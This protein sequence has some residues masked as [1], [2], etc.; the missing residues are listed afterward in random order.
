MLTL[1]RTPALRIAPGTRKSSTLDREPAAAVPAK[2]V[3]EMLLEIAFVLHAT[4]VVAKM[5]PV[6]AAK[7]G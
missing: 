2:Q 6:V 7:K 1:Q 3:R 4:R 5:E